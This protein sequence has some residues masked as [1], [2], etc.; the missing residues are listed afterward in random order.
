MRY[1]KVGNTEIVGGILKELTGADTF[2]IKDGGALLPVYQRASSRQSK[3]A[4]KRAAGA[5]GYPDPASVK[6]IAIILR[7]RTTE[8]RCR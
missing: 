8:A 6:Y 3:S 1:V 7:C 2:K 4:R 5:E